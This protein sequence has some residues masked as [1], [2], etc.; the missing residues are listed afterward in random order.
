MAL[1][2]PTSF[3]RRWGARQLPLAAKLPLTALRQFRRRLVLKSA[4][5]P[6]SL[7]PLNGQLSDRSAFLLM[8]PT[9]FDVFQEYLEDEKIGFD[10]LTESLLVSDGIFDTE[11]FGGTFKRVTLFATPAI[12]PALASPDTDW[13][14]Y[15][16]LPRAAAFAIKPGVI[17]TWTPQ[18]NPVDRTWSLD[19]VGQ[20]GRV[21]LDNSY[22]YRIT[23]PR[24]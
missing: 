23:I 17:R 3:Q 15:G 20:F 10:R 2:V 24:N 6:V 8:H 7:N 5:G 13:V 16:A 21:A 12:P 22:L 11:Q 1:P 9:I 4:L 19:Q 14:F 18:T